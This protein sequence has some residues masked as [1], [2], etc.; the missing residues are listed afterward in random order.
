M[1]GFLTWRKTISG[2]LT[3]IYVLVF[4]LVLLALN[5]AA[6]LGL[7]YFINHNARDSLD[8]TMEF[9]S[10][11]LIQMNFY[12]TELIKD[13]SISEQ[14]IYFRILSVNKRVRFESGLLEDVD[15]PV[16]PG[17]QG[18]KKDGRQFI[19]KTNMIIEQGMF[20]GYI[21]AVRE[22]TSEYRFLR[23][24]L[25]IMSIA[26]LFGIIAAVI[27]GY[28]ITRKTLEPISS[29]TETARE[30]SGSDI[31]K[32]LEISGPED[33]LTDMANT[34]NSMLDRLES[35]FQRQ[36]QFVSDASHELRTPISVIQGYANL[37]DRWGKEDKEVRDEAI[38]AVKKEAVNMKSLVEGLLFLAR[39][40]DNR[41][42]IN[43]I[44]FYTD[45]LL[46][47]IIQETEMI[48]DR[49]NVYSK[50]ID[51]AQLYADR[52]LLKQMLRIF[53][54][55]SIKYTPSGGNIELNVIDNQDTIKFVI[56]DTGIGIPEED[57]PHVFERF[58]RV[59]KSRSDKK[60]TG[61][62]L[63]IARWIIKQHDGEVRVESSPGEG[64]KV[65]VSIPLVLEEKSKS[66]R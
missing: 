7:S 4:I 51:S 20:I 61:L 64:T 14:N 52:E 35:A 26:S 16:V 59:D 66:K 58:Y 29:I 21:Q 65:T 27:T 45:E 48:V 40:D 18:F 57:I 3:T 43:K 46:D 34:F 33:E 10:N 19:Y 1:S 55:N 24:L 12:D 49:I 28:T 56:K 23:I 13:V 8:N 38:E 42:E 39:S 36:R 53:V 2:R 62:G 22:M 47:E 32:R 41:M 50:R 17:Y 31:S 5:I 6:Y 9:L 30:I 63:S 25:T 15:I 11:R 60:G 44:N 54:D 37:L